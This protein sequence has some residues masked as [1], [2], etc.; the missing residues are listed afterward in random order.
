[1]SDNKPDFRAE[2][3]VWVR[4]AECI[5]GS[6]DKFYEVRIDMGDDGTFYVTKRWGRRPDAGGGQIKVEPYQNMNAAQAVAL[7]MLNEKRSKG[8]RET[9]R[10]FGA[11]QR[12]RREY[13]PDYYAPDT[14]AF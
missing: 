13:G 5:G 7:N 11:G 10:P 14:E 2:E 9:E 6:H 3:P 4:Y 12:V 1:M 8:Y